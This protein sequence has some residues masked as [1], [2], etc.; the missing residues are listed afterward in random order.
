MKRLHR[1]D[2]PNCLSDYRA[3]PD[4]WDGE[5]G[6]KGKKLNKACKK[7]VRDA[8]KTMQSR[9]CAYCER[10]IYKDTD[11]KDKGG[12]IEHFVQKGGAPHE[13][14][15]WDN[16]FWSCMQ[17]M[18]CGKHKD[19]VNRTTYTH[20]DLLKPDVDDPL[21]FLQYDVEGRVLPKGEL[22]PAKLVRAR[23]TIR[24][25]NL[26]SH[27]ARLPRIRLETW[28]TVAAE[29]EELQEL[30]GDGSFTTDELFDERERVISERRTSEFSACVRSLVELFLPLPQA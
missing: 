13:T 14:F 21:Q 8:L 11:D 30:F 18:S 23:Q 24:V 20:A 12:H 7:S 10:T 1:P 29:V 17:K 25:F 16:L 2:A 3:P 4:V 6:P 19:R 5:P 26:N 22:A 27:E 9:T 15:S 28:T